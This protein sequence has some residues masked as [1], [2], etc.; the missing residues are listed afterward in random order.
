MS[1]QLKLAA[2][3][4]E[5]PFIYI[6]LSHHK[7]GLERMDGR[8]VRHSCQ[9]LCWSVSWSPDA[10]CGPIGW[11]WQSRAAA[12]G[13]RGT[14][15]P[16]GQRWSTPRLKPG[17]GPAYCHPVERN[18]NTVMPLSIHKIPFHTIHCCRLKW[19]SHSKCTSHRAWTHIQ[20]TAIALLYISNTCFE[21]CAFEIHPF[22]LCGLVFNRQQL[23]RQGHLWCFTCWLK[24]I[25]LHTCLSA[26]KKQLI[27]FSSFLPAAMCDKRMH[28][29]HTH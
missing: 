16:W 19:F 14:W 5:G 1:F 24:G 29:V 10:C 8:K 27:L 9:H 6:R 7:L 12:P 3:H 28:V 22:K 26:P 15:R 17:T 21:I 18:H 20:S 25:T 23:S 4:Q 11:S 2:V 13:C